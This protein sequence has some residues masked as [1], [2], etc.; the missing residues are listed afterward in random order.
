LERT[1]EFSE[2][3]FVATVTFL[4]DV[5]FL[6][7]RVVLL[8]TVY[9]GAVPILD[10]NVSAQ[11]VLIQVVNRRFLIIMSYLLIPNLSR[12][13]IFYFAHNNSF[14]LPQA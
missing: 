11:I 13:Q 1:Q 9:S 3:I 10:Q 14:Q 5:D 12:T 2:F 8:T 4:R 7:F 6:L